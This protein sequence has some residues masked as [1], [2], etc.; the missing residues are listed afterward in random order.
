MSADMKTVTLERLRTSEAVFVLLSDSTRLPYV[1]CDSGTF[2]D[3]ILLFYEEEDA[4]RAATG[5]VRDKTA[6]RVARIENKNFLSFYTS[7]FTLGVN[8]IV[9][10][11]GT[12]RRVSV[13]LNELIRRE[14]PDKLP[15][16]QVRV[17]NPELHLTA[18]YFVQE[19]RKNQ[20][21][22]MTEEL[23]ELYEEM[24]AH[25]GKGRYIVAVGQDQGIPA[26]KGKEG[27][28][29]Q[30]LFTD[31]LEFQK[32]NRENLF[33]AMVVEADKITKLLSKES[34]GVVINP[35]GVNVQFKLAGRE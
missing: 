12:A 26:L 34:S 35:L 8:C 23:K 17:E 29:Y 13:Q 28:V 18:I 15:K 9:I 19:L 22:K 11:D 5:L 1:E 27:Q 32:F 31:F 25:F 4:K 10:N 30:P 6:V 24:L 33:R 3:Q 20:G 7:L 14:G 21:R 16:G 2:D